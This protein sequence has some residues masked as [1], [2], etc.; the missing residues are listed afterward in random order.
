MEGM[1]SSSLTWFYGRGPFAS[2]RPLH[3]LYVCR[4]KKENNKIEKRENY[5]HDIPPF[6]REKPFNIKLAPLCLF[7]LTTINLCKESRISKNKKGGCFR[8]SLAG[9]DVISS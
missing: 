8:E 5:I 1:Q 3:S 9:C 4:R 2:G 7:F 6:F